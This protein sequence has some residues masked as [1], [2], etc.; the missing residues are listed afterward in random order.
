[1]KNDQKR[2]NSS[3]AV[4]S[5][6]KAAARNRQRENPNCNVG[7]L[8]RQ[9]YIDRFL[10]R[11]FSEG[12]RSEWVLKGGSAMLARIPST[13]RTLDADLFREGYGKDESLEELKR[14][15]AVDLHDFFRFEFLSEEPILQGEN[16]PYGDGCRVYFGIFLGTKSL[17]KVHVD[18]AVHQGVLLSGDVMEPRNRLPLPGLESYP[19]R[20]YPIPNQFA[21]KACATVQLVG[22]MQSTRV[23]DLVDLVLI[24]LTQK[25]DARQLSAAL[26]DECAR[27]RIPY[28]LVFAAP[29]LW[30]QKQFRVASAGTSVSDYS[31]ED[32]SR[33]ISRMLDDLYSLGVNT[34]NQWNPQQ[35]L[36]EA[37][38]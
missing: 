16:Q 5:A 35:L 15:A 11:I 14:L 33:L 2:Y 22:G 28:P 24:A 32:A 12:D 25:I 17:G 31:L 9:T 13:R 10:S 27:R 26:Q 34:R 6:I 18:L 38:Q 4:E 3:T 8:I 7:D 19:Y 20:L 1:M 30:T 37:Q 29:S 36:W 21:D 23:K